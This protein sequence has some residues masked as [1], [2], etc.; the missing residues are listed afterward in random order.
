MTFFETVA[1]YLIT[2]S[3]FLV[4]DLVWLGVIARDFYNRELKKFLP[5]KFDMR[6]A[7]LFYGVY[8][9]GVL[10]MVLIPAVNQD[11]LGI[12]MFRGLAFGFFTY[13]TYGLTNWSTIAGWP[14][15]LTFQDIAW[16]TFLGWAVSTISY[17]AYVGIFN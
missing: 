14:T 3:A 17:S 4:I 9:V 8:I 6:R 10:V 16:G 11:S 2:L 1:L 5:K 15:R 12:A 13:A 7:F